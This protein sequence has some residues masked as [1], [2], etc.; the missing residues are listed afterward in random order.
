MTDDQVPRSRFPRWLLTGGV[1]LAVSLAAYVWNPELVES[2]LRS[3]RAL[4]FI[5]VVVAV[6]VVIGR[7]AG[8]RWPVLARGAQAV[9]VLAVLAVTVLPTL[10]DTEVDE[11]LG[12]TIVPRA[13]GDTSPDASP[14][15]SPTAASLSEGTATLLGQGR[16]MELDYEASGRAKLIELPDGGLLVRFE[17]LEVQPGPDYVVYLVAG[18]DAEEPGDGTLLGGLKGNKGNQNYDVP[19]GTDV[20]GTQTALIWCRAFAVPVANATLA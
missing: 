16:F 1:V 10:R 5:A 9:L 11:K 18:E 19:P 14:S 6:V 7:L 12:V 8:P 3:P 17:D 20:G 4:A 13:S 15:P 2:T